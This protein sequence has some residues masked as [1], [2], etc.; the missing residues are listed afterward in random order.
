MGMVGRF[1]DECCETH[2]QLMQAVLERPI[3]PL[4]GWLHWDETGGACGCLIGTMALA[5][6]GSMS[7]DDDSETSIRDETGEVDVCYYVAR[8]LRLRDHD[9]A[10]VGFQV[11]AIAEQCGSEA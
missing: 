11:F 7:L 1:I 8:H 5:A 2:P 3:G 6:G 4:G 10:D 9:V